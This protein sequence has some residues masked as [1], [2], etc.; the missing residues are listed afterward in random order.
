[1]K[2]VIALAL[3]I[4]SVNATFANSGHTLKKQN[5]KIGSCETGYD[6]DSA[7]FVTLLNA[8]ATVESQNNPNA[9]GDQ[10]QAAGIFQLH[11]CA[12]LDVNRKY[13]TTFSWPSDCL[14]PVT[15]QQIAKLYLVIC[16]YGKKP[17]EETIR[18][19][20]GGGKHW[21]SNAAGRYWEKVKAILSSL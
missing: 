3:V 21:Q 8:I 15:A 2:H 16:G 18:R 4:L 6:T 10:N 11:R 13:R 14:N 12:L 5:E 17:L 1:M 19:Y 7:N 9:M 20:N